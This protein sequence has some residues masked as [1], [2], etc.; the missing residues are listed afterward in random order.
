[1]QN[2]NDTRK[3]ARIFKVSSYAVSKCRSPLCK[4]LVSWCAIRKILIPCIRFWITSPV[5]MANGYDK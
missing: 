3:I 2:C 1:M 4:L 5:L